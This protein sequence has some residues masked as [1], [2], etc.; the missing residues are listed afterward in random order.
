[1]FS[2]LSCG[3]CWSYHVQLWNCQCSKLLGFLLLECSKLW[4][5]QISSEEEV[6]I[7][8]SASDIFFHWQFDECSFADVFPSAFSFLSNIFSIR[9]LSFNSLVFTRIT[10]VSRR[11]SLKV[12]SITCISA[13]SQCMNGA[14]NGVIYMGYPCGF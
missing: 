2:K 5:W 11:K 1:M 10:N 4:Y 8:T 14:Y 6:F 7:T 12:E 13:L 3:C 9:V